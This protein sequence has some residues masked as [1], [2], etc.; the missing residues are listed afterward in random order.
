MICNMYTI[1]LQYLLFSYGQ[2]KFEN[3]GIGS[4]E[5]EVEEEGGVKLLGGG[6][7][8]KSILFVYFFLLPL[9]I[10]R[11]KCDSCVRSLPSSNW[12]S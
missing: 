4:T 11:K 2:F 8:L 12:E 10:P 9:G 1:L 6:C 7:K 5:K 3:G